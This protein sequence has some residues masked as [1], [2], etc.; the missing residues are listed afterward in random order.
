ME[1]GGGGGG[2]GAEIIV[3]QTNDGTVSQATWGKLVRVV[4][5]H[6]PA[7]P[8]EQMLHSGLNV[9]LLLLLETTILNDL[10]MPLVSRTCAW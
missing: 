6:I 9:V 7:V 2:G 5:Q 3:S 4:V 1:G 10:K 8:S